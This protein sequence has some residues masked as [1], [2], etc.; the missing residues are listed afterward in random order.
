M[1]PSLR[2]DFVVDRRVEHVVRDAAAGR[3][4]GLHGL[5]ATAVRAAAADVIDELAERGAERHLD[6]AGVLDLA[7]QRE[8][9]GAGAGLALPIAVNHAGPLATM[10]G[11]LNQ[12]STLLMFVGLP[13]RPFCAGYGGRGRGRPARPRAR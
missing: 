3:P 5:D 4:A 1:E 6:K 13:H 12:V 8:D 2:Q 7:H 11:M 9:L 10:G